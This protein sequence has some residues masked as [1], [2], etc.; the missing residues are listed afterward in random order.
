MEVKDLA[1]VLKWRNSEHVRRQSLTDHIIKLND[2][3]E[4][5]RD[6]DKDPACEWLIAE[7]KDKPIGVVSITDINSQN[8][9]CTWGMY[10]GENIGKLGIGVLMEIRAIDR[11]FNYHR[12]RR[13]WGQ[14]L[15]SNRILLTHKKFGFVEEGI[16]KHHIFKNGNYEDVVLVALFPEKWVNAREKI[17]ETYNLFDK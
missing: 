4:W 16:L 15:K 6:L 17:F 7:F 1:M 14:V 5:F 10:T 8:S 3:Q 11:I 2:H 12:I 13:L 9:T